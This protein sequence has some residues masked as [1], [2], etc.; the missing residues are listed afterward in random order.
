MLKY[1]SRTVARYVFA[2]RYILQPEGLLEITSKLA[3]LTC[4]VAKAYAAPKAD[5]IAMW[6][7]ATDH[8]LARE[9]RSE[10]RAD[11]AEGLAREHAY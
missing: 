2:D 1:A 9:Q 7:H 11:G 6:R 5:R 8:R 10:K 4:R 3:R